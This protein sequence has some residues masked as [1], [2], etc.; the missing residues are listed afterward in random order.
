MLQHAKT[1][2]DVSKNPQSMVGSQL[3]LEEMPSKQFVGY[4]SEDDDIVMSERDNSASLVQHNES[5]KIGERKKSMLRCSKLRQKERN[6]DDFDDMISSHEE[7]QN[8]DYIPPNRDS[9]HASA[10][11]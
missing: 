5:G 7:S 10:L 2:V 8:D 3:K 4:N 11:H 9:M 6:N 1:L